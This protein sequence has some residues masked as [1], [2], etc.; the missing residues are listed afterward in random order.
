[1][2]YELKP[3]NGQMEASHTA[4]ELDA[5]TKYFAGIFVGAL[6]VLVAVCCILGNVM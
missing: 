2:N 5:T 6:A 3:A 4:K 1:M